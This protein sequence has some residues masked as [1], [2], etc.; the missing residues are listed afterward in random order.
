[1]GEQLIGG[2]HRESR[3]RFGRQRA[4]PVPGLR[5]D[6]DAGTAWGDDIAELLKHQRGAVQIDRQDCSRR[7]LAG[8]DAGGVDDAGDVIERRSGLTSV[9]T[10]SRDDTSTVAVLTSNPALP[11]ISAAASA[12]SGRRSANTT[13]LSALTRRAIAW[14]IDPCQMTTTS[15]LKRCPLHH[16]LDFQAHDW[17]PATNQ[18]LP[19]LPGATA[20]SDGQP[21]QPVLCR[22][23]LDPIPG[24]RSACGQGS[25]PRPE[26]VEGARARSGTTGSMPKPRSAMPSTRIGPPSGD[27]STD[28]Y[29]RLYTYCWPPDTSEDPA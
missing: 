24:Y 18:A 4:Q 9:C 21:Q 15:S 6:H 22:P 23:L 13:C 16:L 26:P 7:C 25:Y 1:M 28:R 17:T 12:F 3:V 14:P 10:D 8:G 11:S 27:S 20:P 19:G 5:G 2:R 29:R